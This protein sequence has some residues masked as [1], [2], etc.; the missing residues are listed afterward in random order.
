MTAPGLLSVVGIGPGGRAH[1]THAADEALGAAN[2]VIGY[3]PYLDQCADALAAG[4]RVVRGEMGDEAGR[5]ARA[6]DEARAG[7]RVALVSS[8]DAGVYGMAT[9]ALEAAAALPE[10]DRPRI[11]VVPGVTA[12]LASAAAVGAPLGHDFATISLS[13]LLTPWNAIEVR[14]RAAAQADFAIALYNPRSGRR[15]WQ[16]DAARRIL[17][18]HRPAATPVAVVTDATR[19][20]EHLQLTTLADLDTT[21]ASMTS[22]VLIGSSSTLVVGDRM[23]TPRGYPA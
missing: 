8:G 12:A 4:Q 3:G 15:T 7:A 13:D 22:C 16:L 21:D 18:E 17:L 2:V 1:R 20:D 14:L 9:L 11:E 23:V 5:A 10:G 6:V 19:A